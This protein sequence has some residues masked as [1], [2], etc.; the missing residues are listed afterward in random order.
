MSTCPAGAARTGSSTRSMR[1]SLARNSF[2]DAVALYD[3]LG[4]IARLLVDHRHAHALVLRP[5][6]LLPAVRVREGAVHG[7][8]LLGGDLLLL[9]FERDEAAV[10][11]VALAIA[12]RE[13]VDLALR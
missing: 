8:L 3:A 2:S 13:S 12:A 5:R 9:V 6:R 11:H 10:E 1:R 7:R 4:A